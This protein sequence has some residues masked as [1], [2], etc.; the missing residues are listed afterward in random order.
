MKTKIKNLISGNEYEAIQVGSTYQIIGKDGKQYDLTFNVVGEN[1]ILYQGNYKNKFE[2][3]DINNSIF[4]ES[5]KWKNRNNKIT[6]IEVS[7]KRAG[8]SD[9]EAFKE[10]GID[11]DL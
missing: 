8:Y 6:G 5:Y 2:I 10:M 7:N 1:Y 3:I 9:K 4:A 11:N